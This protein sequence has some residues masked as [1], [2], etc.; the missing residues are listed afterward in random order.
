MQCGSEGGGRKKT[1]VSQ[2]SSGGKKRPEEGERAGSG[3]R[4]ESS[5]CPGGSKLEPKTR[6]RDC[7]AKAG[8]KMISGTSKDGS[9]GW[10]EAGP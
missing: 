1:G 5:A 4:P 9:Q 6:G 7:P 3:Q 2:Q 8:R 10:R